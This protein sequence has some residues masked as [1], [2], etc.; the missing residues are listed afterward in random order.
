[1]PLIKKVELQEPRAN[2]IN[3]HTWRMA[4][5]DVPLS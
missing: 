2:V 4:C 5:S 1:M 3:P